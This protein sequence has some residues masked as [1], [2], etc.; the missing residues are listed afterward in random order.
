MGS[1]DYQTLQYISENNIATI[2]LNRPKAYNAFTTDM[3]KEITHALKSAAKNDAIRCVV[4]T[5][6]GKAFCAGEDLAGVDENTNHAEFLR[7]RYHPMM[8][9]IKEFSKPIIA[10]VNGTAAGAGMSLALAADFRLVQPETKF[11]S[12]FMNIGLVPDSGFMYSLPRL[13]GYAKAL[14]IAV[15]GKPITGEEA[16]QLG[17]ATEVIDPHN[18]EAKVQQFSSSV[19]A[20]P[21]KAFA[22][23]KRYM[24]DGMHQP[25]E[26]FLENEAQAQRIAGMTDDHQEGLRAFQEKRKPE[27]HGK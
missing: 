22:L 1:E 15:L 4:I 5:G 23:I 3:N 11:I 17:L 6:N 26:D 2:K 18:W 10:A 16:L 19:A 8:K 27:F 13:V 20:M 24:Q 14:E 21:T 9:A 12:A 25:Y 7:K